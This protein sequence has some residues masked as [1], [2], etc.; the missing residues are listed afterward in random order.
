M[1]EAVIYCRVST[2]QQVKGHSLI[3]QAETCIDWA[4]KNGYYV[5]SIFSEIG[6]A[7]PPNMKAA[8]LPVLNQAARTARIRKTSLI[9]E[10]WDR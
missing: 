8:S 5:T 7:Y 3:R 4:R 9:F 1:K 6:S 2:A 10:H